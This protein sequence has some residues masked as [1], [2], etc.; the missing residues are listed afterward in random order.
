MRARVWLLV[1]V[2]L[3]LGAGP[4]AAGSASPDTLRAPESFVQ[5]HGFLRTGALVVTVDMFILL[6]N[7]EVTETPDHRIAWNNIVDNLKNGFEWDDNRFYVN[8]V[9]HPYQ[10]SLY[11][12]AA[13]ANGYSYWQSIPWAFA[14]SWMWE[15]LYETNNPSINDWVNSGLGGAAIGESLHRLS[16]VVLDNQAR[17]GERVWRE[18]LGL[19]IAP[20]RGLN[21]LITGEAYTVHRNAADRRPGRGMGQIR[22]GYRSLEEDRPGPTATEEYAFV[23]LDARYGDPFRTS[24]GGAFRHFDFGIAFHVDDQ[25]FA[26]AR[27]RVDG[28]LG[29]EVRGASSRHF[30]GAYQHFD[31]ADHNAYEFGKQS[32][33]LSYLGRYP[34]RS[35]ELR[36]A[37]RLH[38]VIL[39]ASRTDYYNVSGRDFDYGPGLGY[40]VSLGLSGGGPGEYFG[41]GRRE[42]FI[43][44]MNGND[45]DH[46][47]SFTRASLW[48]PLGGLLAAGADYTLYTANR[49]YRR[50]PDVYAR[51]DESRVYLSWVIR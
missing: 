21:R 14:G 9:Y 46:L 33:S 34:L 20:A 17:G 25:E 16:G 35:L 40:E 39:G 32:V 11:F 29:G 50:F 2:A 45:A 19:V 48:V 8:H 36:A 18:L 28:L 12:T 15:F 23:E 49:T 13:R 7:R 43:H 10:G 4:A 27:I 42:Y 38:G 44:S 31:Y 5:S 26:I 51:S 47:V 1:L 24:V 6:Y 41:I 3:L 37:G 22:F 30:V